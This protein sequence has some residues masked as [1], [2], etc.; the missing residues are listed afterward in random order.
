MNIAPVPTASASPQS[1]FSDASSRFDLPEPIRDA[2]LPHERIV[3]AQRG[4]GCRWPLIYTA[5]PVLQA[6]FTAFAVYLLQE[7]NPGTPAATRL[8]ILLFGIAAVGL[9]L[10]QGARIVFGPARET[11]VLTD[12][13]VINCS[14]FL[15]PMVRSLTVRSVTGEAEFP[16]TRIA[17]WGRR[18]RG[19]IM[20]RADSNEGRWQKGAVNITS[21]VGVERPL[22]VASLIRTTLNLNFEIEDHT[23]P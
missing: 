16:I 3:W 9:I 23:R 8:F 1:S 5:L 15:R 17:I 20:L 6:A 12:H 10:L 11:Y 7:A 2:L 14:M 22:E 18:G 13:R 19:W 21:L 4:K